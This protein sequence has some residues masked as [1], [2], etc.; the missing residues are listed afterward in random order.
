MASQSF[1]GLPPIPTELKSI[2]SFIQR[3][4]ELKTQ[5]PVVA[6]WCAY[7]A[8]QQGIALKAPSPANR[9]FL[10]EL[11][12]VLE[13]LRS[14]IGPS[15][16]VNVDSTSCNY[17]EDFALRVFNVADNED[18]A[19]KATRNTAKKFLAAA[20]FLEVLQIFEDKGSWESHT[21]KVRYAKWKAADIA[22]AFR[23]GRTPNPGPAG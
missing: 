20:T 3:A 4:D 13:S 17:V 16:A 19:G 8:A 22:K 14:T 5:D 11:L 18:R 1:L 10:S 2:T 6:Y 7:Y 21:A 9:K 23:E 12:T 15:D